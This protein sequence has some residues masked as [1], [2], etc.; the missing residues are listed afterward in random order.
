M[1]G[2]IARAGVFDSKILFK[3]I[4]FVLMLAG[5]WYFSSVAHA[6]GRTPGSF[7]VS[8]VG[9]ATY[10]IPIWAP[11][12][13]VGMQPHIALTYNSGQ[14]NG[15]VGV[16][17]AIGGLSSIHRC[18]L[19]F[20]QDGAPAPV[21]LAT[22]DGLC[23]DGQRLRLTGGT[24]GAA[25]AT[26]QTEVAN[27]SNVT[28]SSAVT[29]NGASYFTVQAS[30]GVTYLYG[31]TD[32]N[33]NGANSQV[34]AYGSDP[35][36]ASAWMLSKV[37]DP[38]G[39][40]YV[41]NYTA[42]EGA[43]IPNT[44]LWTPTAQG[45]A[46]Y[47]Y[48]MQ[49]NYT[50][51][52]PQS[53]IYGYIAGT[54]VVNAKLL[55]SITV[56]YAGTLV[57]NY[58]LGYQFSPTT[59]REELQTLTECAD[60]GA[61][62]CL[63]PTTITY[64]SGTAGVAASATSTSVTTTNTSSGTVQTQWDFNGDGYLDIAFVSGTTVYVSFG[65]ASGYGTPISTGITSASAVPIG[66]LLG[67]GKDG[68]LGN[69]GGVWY[70]YTWNGS[71]FSG[72]TTGVD[73]TGANT[74]LVDVNGDGF[75]DLVTWT[76]SATA[77]HISSRLNMGNGTAVSF[78]STV[79][80]AFDS[81]S[82]SI[83]NYNTIWAPGSLGPGDKR[84]W[85][86]DGS[87][88]EGLLWGLTEVINGETNIFVQPLA[89]AGTTFTEVG[90]SPG[91]FTAVAGGPV[92]PPAPIVADWNGDGCDDIIW[93][94]SA[95]SG[96]V[97]SFSPC[98]AAGG[99]EPVAIGSSV[100]AVLDW[101]GDGRADAIYNNGGTIGVTLSTGE[102]ETAQS[103]TIPFDSNC[104]Y[105]KMD[106][107]ADGLDDLG[108]WNKST[109]PYPVS[110]QLHN[111]AG[112]P[113]DLLSKITDGY[114]NSAA[115]T[116]ISIAQGVDGMFFPGANAPAAGYQNYV[117]PL[118]VVNGATFSDPTSSTGGTYSQAHYYS[119]AWMNLQG[120]GFAG[121]E[122][123]QVADS[124]NNVWE[125]FEYD[126]AF[127]YTG[128]LTE[129]VKNL[130]NT[131]SGTI[132]YVNYT[133]ACTI[134]EETTPCPATSQRY[135]PY[136]SNSTTY[137]YELGT[138]PRVV[139]TS[140]TNYVLDAYG[141]PKSI[142]TSV[143]DNDTGSP[144]YG[145]VWTQT[146]INMTDPDP[147]SWCLNLLSDSTVTY[148]ATI[149]TSV[150]YTQQFTPDTT[151]C[152]YTGVVT[153]ASSNYTV[154]EAF[155]YDGF[156]NITTD[157]VT[158]YAMTP[159]TMTA[160]WGTTGQ[161]PMSVTDASGATT[162]FNYNF[163]FDLKIGTTDPNGVKTSW[164]YDGFGRIA[165][166]SRPDGTFTQWTYNNCSTSGSCLIGSNT[167]ILTFGVY[168]SNGSVLTD[169]STWFD[170]LQ[171]PYLANKRM[172]ANSTYDRNEVRYDNLGRIVEQAAPCTMSTVSATCPYI[173]T[174]GYDVLN[175]VTSVARPTSASISKLETTYYTYEG[176]TTLVQDPTPNTTTFVNDVNGW[177]RQTTDPYGYTVTTAYD[178][179]GNK[180]SVT[181]SAN[182]PLWSGTYAYGTSPFLVSVTD[183]D[184]GAW[185]ST[186]DALGERTGWQD[187]KGQSF[188]AT[189][190]A[191]SRPLTRT[192]PDQFTQWTW[193]ASAASYNIG[194][195]QSVCM[196]PAPA[197]GSAGACTSSY[198]SE[199]ETYD[200]L[201]RASQ[202][203]I[204]IP[205]TG[206]FTY[207]WAYNA[208]T[209][210]LNTLTYPASTS[211]G[212]LQLQYGYQNGLP[213][214][215]TAVLPNTSNVTV[216]QANTTDP[217]G[218]ITQE[219]LGNGIVTN[220]AFDADTGWLSS[221]QS[222]VSGGTGVQN[223][224][225]LYDLVGDIIQR[226]DNNL[227]LTENIYYDNDYRL[228]YTTLSGTEAQLCGTVN[229]SVT[230][231]VTGNITSR[232][233]VASGATWTYD[234]VRKHAVT[235]A[236]SSA[237]DYSYDA[238]G[239]AITR[240]GSSIAWSSYNYPTSISAGSGSTAETVAFSYSPSRQRW[241]QIYNGNSTTETT[242]Y[243]GQQLEIVSSGGVTDYRHYIYAGGR[244]VAV[245]SR[246]ST[247][248]N[249][250]SYVL[251]DH[252][253]SVYSLTN[254]SVT[255]NESFTP[256]GARRS[257]TTWS[258][259]DTTLDLTT[260]AGISRE[261]Y[262]FQTQ[263]GLW[264]GLNHMNGRV[265]DAVTGRFLS[266]DPYV[267]NPANS[268]SYNRFSYAMNNPLTY[269]DPSGFDD[270]DGGGWNEQEYWTPSIIIPP[271]PDTF[272][273]GLDTGLPNL[274]DLNLPDPDPTPPNPDPTPPDPDLPIPPAPDPIN[275]QGINFPDSGPPP[276]TPSLSALAAG[277]TIVPAGTGAPPQSQPS[278]GGSRVSATIT[279]LQTLFTWWNSPTGSCNCITGAPNL[280]GG[281]V[282]EIGVARGAAAAAE[283]AIRLHHTWPK[284]LGGAAEQDLVPLSKSLHDAFH[285]G[286]D[287]ILP[288]QWGSAYYEGLS[289]AARQQ[290]LGDLAAY[291][292]AFDAKNGTQLYDAMIRNGFPG[293]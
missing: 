85:H 108:C 158:G 240:Q 212:P 181:D 84:S 238:N 242:D 113:P 189:Y 76:T 3:S 230:Y 281:L 163:G 206:T 174:M 224:S 263:L 245:L 136:A 284:Y 126:L 282:G 51:N 170:P 139:T 274:S 125:T 233:D 135:F 168:N 35:A 208:T 222:G 133:L 188:S 132:G 178:A 261:G 79:N 277:L 225:F 10:T 63:M 44:I 199:S 180:T 253:N 244:A 201:E 176:R 254:S 221:V 226:Q 77:V 88:R 249:T 223:Q 9:A 197:S 185:S 134:P 172:L 112:Q 289:Q 4:P 68:I 33:G 41:I 110:Y 272:P 83:C 115:P 13:P 12:G 69:N 48:S 73:Y 143:T 19:T 25:S 70:Y 96:N 71:S 266:A 30:N 14:G 107:N 267:P 127:P 130:G 167:L 273:S 11:L 200:F 271:S 61:T 119:G 252:Q 287:K 24:Y 78:S 175:R 2:R 46:T 159:R 288:R 153:A 56:S 144:Y 55:S 16:G 122:A 145:D 117:G 211:S 29:G 54:P 235:Q 154:T 39:N 285:S 150:T 258:G 64:Q 232:C 190:D 31:Y 152:R 123:H 247:G 82:C 38:A 248:T 184:L 114:G 94:A 23:L 293:P 32:A 92:P 97:V 17:W 251:S 99:S 100:A 216:W 291:T 116:Y 86:F 198:Y 171:R 40:N 256:F 280:V 109:S 1:F 290:V 5:A 74:A 27:F 57:K 196:G 62:N 18:D 52:P 151:H 121:F 160:N 268:Q 26:Y 207:T 22:S 157:T 162:Q 193:G 81:S 37:I 34:V 91:L 120:R 45:G 142:A 149:G 89:G 21:A 202:R 67:T 210:L 20:A 275:P 129:D 161:L 104:I 103:T 118:Y 286:L 217:A 6:V 7:A 276:S 36:T 186:V 257:P 209:G 124:R 138:T 231:D 42:L 283:D 75:P 111:S 66:D 65:S 259:A 269:T 243:V 164:I 47:A 213:L 239:N 264:M 148:G 219:T 215:V 173:T 234:P 265:Q 278:R 255:V 205:S 220:R 15:S 169:G 166:E 80:D 137:T 236:G 43:A 93:Q 260:S 141:N 58:V 229:L 60:S 203:A 8:R 95:A 49:F 106:A 246:K 105:F 146:I 165:Q 177:L 140:S 279:A 237:Y 270:S 228:S 250:W 72:T 147:T 192:E 59:A 128:M 204:T 218:H 292:K 98:G 182:N 214:S 183:M 227:G 90:W 156:G 195:L 187:A 53:S 179:E 50:T 131:A 102:S 87:R 28:A 101:N 262:T 191:L 241:Q 155:G 194:K